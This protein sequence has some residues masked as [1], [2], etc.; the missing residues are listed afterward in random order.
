[1]VNCQEHVP[2]WNAASVASQSSRG[3]SE[4]ELMICERVMRLTR[5]GRDAYNKRARETI[6]NAPSSQRTTMTRREWLAA[7]AAIHAAVRTPATAA[8]EPKQGPAPLD[9]RDFQPRSML[10]VAETQ[11]PRARFPAIDFHTHLSFSAAGK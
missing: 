7:L 9:I 3:T 1:M 6:E 4:Y 5:G 2:W 10:H 11:V 8:Q